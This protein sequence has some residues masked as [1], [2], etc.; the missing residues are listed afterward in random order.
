[1]P[2]A[3][4]GG[5]ACSA[6]GRVGRADR[7]TDCRRPPV[8]EIF[9]MPSEYSITRTVEFCETDMAGIM[10]FSNYFRWMEACEAAFYRSL[11]LPLIS[12]VPGSVVG[13]PR[14]KVSCDYKAP[15]RFNDVIEVKL[16]IKELR[17]KGVVYVFQFRKLE[18]GAVQ[19]PIVAQGEMAAV[20][21][22]SDATGKLIAQP[23]PEAVRAKLAVADP[24]AFT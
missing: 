8:E 18:A 6:S 9:P 10:H 24:A 19:P 14:V 7:K 1:V 21:V 20:C 13:W 11:D 5:R 16:F 23:I 2:A 15:L 22:T 12:F 17:T 4:A 3:A